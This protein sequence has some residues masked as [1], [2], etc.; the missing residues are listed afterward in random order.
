MPTATLDGL[1]VNYL[2]RGSGPALLMLAPGGFDR[3]RSGDVMRRI[4]A[5]VDSLQDFYARSLL[6]PVA[7]VLSLGLLAAIAGMLSARLG[8]TVL[9]SCVALGLGVVGAGVLG[10]RGAAGR[11]AALSG[12][13]A[14]EVTETLQGC[15]DLAGVGALDARLRAIDALNRDIARTATRLAWSRAAGWRRGN[16]CRN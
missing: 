6:P 14:A 7:A 13:L 12:V 8:V 9:V 5:D 15:A 1:E 3:E 4:T 11:L 16:G 2:T 10:A